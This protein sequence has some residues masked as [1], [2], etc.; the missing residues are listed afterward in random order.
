MDDS[1]PQ[2]KKQRVASRFVNVRVEV[3]PCD[4][5]TCTPEDK[6]VC[7]F[8]TFRIDIH[9]PTDVELLFLPP[10]DVKEFFEKRRSRS[11]M[12][13]IYMQDGEDKHS[14]VYYRQTDMKQSHVMSQFQDCLV[15]SFEYG[16][17]NLWPKT[18]TLGYLPDSNLGM[19]RHM[20]LSGD[21]KE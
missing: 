1:E 10:L 12:V 20:G 3:T 11:M 18:F 6:K 9:Q 19:I 5:K 13:E 16:S 8:F 17:V 14:R 7:H 21:P 15:Y 2:K 4:S